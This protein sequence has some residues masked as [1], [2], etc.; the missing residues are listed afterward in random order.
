[1]NFSIHT[2]E[3]TDKSEFESERKAKPK[4]T[5]LGKGITLWECDNGYKLKKTCNQSNKFNRRRRLFETLETYRKE[6]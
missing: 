6:H 5:Q 1:M 4:R 2:F 3:L